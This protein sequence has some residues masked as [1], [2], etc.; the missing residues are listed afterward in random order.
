MERTA[1]LTRENSWDISFQ[2][3]QDLRRLAGYWLGLAGRPCPRQLPHMF[4]LV[5]L[6]L[7]VQAM[8]W[9]EALGPELAQRLTAECGRLP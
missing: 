6:G 4:Q 2:E 1:V 8:P 3:A 9:P 5:A 7:A